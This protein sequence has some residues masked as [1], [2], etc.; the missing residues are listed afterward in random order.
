MDK[1]IAIEMQKEIVKDIGWIDCMF[2]F[3]VIGINEFCNFKEFTQMIEN[4]EIS[5]WSQII[6]FK[7]LSNNF[8]K[9]DDN[10]GD[11]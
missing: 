10:R 3:N 7:L 1:W 8:W 6:M 2:I 11:I 9:V 4:S 5:F